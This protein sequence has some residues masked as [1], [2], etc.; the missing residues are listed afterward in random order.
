MGG[1]QSMVGVR[2]SARGYRQ[3]MKLMFAIWTTLI[4]AGIVYYTIVGLTHG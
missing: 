2:R 3:R 1:G 4:I